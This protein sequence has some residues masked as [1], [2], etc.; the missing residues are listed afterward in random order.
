[1]KLQKTI[2]INSI[3]VFLN[4]LSN[5]PGQY[6]P[7][8][9]VIQRQVEALKL[10]G[11]A[12]I[13]KEPAIVDVYAGE[14]KNECNSTLIQEPV[15]RNKPHLLP[16]EAIYQKFPQEF[17]ETF[18]IALSYLENPQKYKNTGV[19]IPNK[20]LLYGPPGCGK[21]YLAQLIA[22]EFQLPFIY[23]KASDFFNKYMGESAKKITQAFSNRDSK[24]RPLLLF[25]DEID[26]IGSKRSGDMYMEHRAMV[27]ALLVELQKIS[28]D[29][30]IFVIVATNDKEILDEAFS[31]RFEGLCVEIKAMGQHQR[32]LLVRDL[33]D[34]LPVENREKTIKIIARAAKGLS[35]RTISTAIESAHA[36]TKYQSQE[37]SLITASSILLFINRAR[38]NHYESYAKKISKFLIDS[39]PHLNSMYLLMNILGSG[40]HFF[41]FI[42]YVYLQTSTAQRI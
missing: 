31:N 9:I 38:Q 16:S 26:A 18:K 36:W 6:L 33:L 15:S 22:Q 35:R 12:E 19:K 5:D 30:S 41:S 8:E 3:I 17:P 42:Q 24:G 40:Y 11:Q 27:N 34:E 1:M 20:F 25:I 7:A 37:N 28:F 4:L 2:V 14:N 32:E 10:L 23:L 29:A 21:S 39:A 13:P